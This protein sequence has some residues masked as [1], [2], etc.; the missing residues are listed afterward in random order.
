MDRCSTSYLL[1]S[2]ISVRL[3]PEIVQ[4]RD[5]ELG[6]NLVR[7]SASLGER[8]AK[9]GNRKPIHGAVPNLNQL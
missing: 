4:M 2:I 5:R 3:L 6:T 8:G 7:E 1:A 9:I